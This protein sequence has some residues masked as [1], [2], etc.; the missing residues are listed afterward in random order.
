M[1]N[2]LVRFMI[3]YLYML[4]TMKLMGK[5]QIGEMQMTELITAFFL[6]EMA[7]YTVTDEEIP[8]LFGLVPI[9]ILICIEVIISFLAVKIPIMKR[10]F[11][12]SPSI[13]ID[14]GKVLEKELLNNR[15]TLDELL[16]LL[17][18]CGYYRME[19]VRFAILEPNG[20]L[21]VVPF[22]SEETITCSD[23][24]LSK[25]ENGFTVAVI[26]DG[27]INQKALQ[28]IGK[29]KAWL[30]KKLKREKILDPKEVFLFASDFSE[31]TK[32]IRKEQDKE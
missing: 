13:L 5:R 31:N 11:D 22:A 30:F 18:L 8:I 16:S 6:S 4:I 28:A 1:Y 10:I 17:R 32:L 26:D 21:S 19:Q 12:F 2:L 7:T 20:Q 24:N 23:L 9:L 14:E 3:V 25:K 15:L 27:K 29:N